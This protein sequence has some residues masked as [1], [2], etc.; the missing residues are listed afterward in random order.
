MRVMLLLI[1]LVFGTAAYAR[2]YL[3]DYDS[4]LTRGEQE[5]YLKGYK[6]GLQHASE[7]AL[8]HYLALH[9]E[10]CYAS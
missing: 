6:L 2:D 8:V 3:V 4:L 10:D 5:A 1:V 7:D 9:K